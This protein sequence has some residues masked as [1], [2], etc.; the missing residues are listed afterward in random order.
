MQLSSLARSTDAS[1]LAVSSARFR[2][3]SSQT[4]G[5]ENTPSCS[6]LLSLSSAVPYRPALWLLPCSSSADWSLATPWD[7]WSA[8][9]LSTKARLHRPRFVAFS[10][11]CTGQASRL[12][13]SQQAG[14][15]LA[16]I[17]RAAS[18]YGD[19]HLPFKVHGLCFSYLGSCSF[20]NLPDGVSRTQR[21]RSII[22]DL[23]TSPVLTKNRPEEALKAFTACRTESGPTNDEHAINE[24]FH[25]LRL[26]VIEE[27]KDYV[28]LT[29][30]FKRP[31]LRKRCFIGW[32]T[33][34]AGQCTGTIVIN[35]Q[36]F[37]GAS[38]FIS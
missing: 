29:D 19:S 18:K 9:F 23:T 11:E 4:N 32:L 13:T 12:A 26:Q 3:C 16:S 5:V 14:L 27:M 33:M 2:V 22:E 15:A 24:E 36:S 10:S 31:A 30:F 37:H 8:S 20:L 35:S 6:Q 1:V 7:Y 25:L 17:S 38:A 21:K 28:P 34:A